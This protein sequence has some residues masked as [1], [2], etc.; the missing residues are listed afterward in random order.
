MATVDEDLNQLEKDIRQL[1][2]EYE[3]YFGGGRP[4]PPAD[5]VWRIEQVVK[6]YSEKGKQLNFAQRF[7]FN[8]LSQTYA[9]YQEVF[10]KRMKK[11][12]E[13]IVERHYGA[14]ARAIEA[15]REKAHAA[16]AERAAGASPPAAGRKPA[17]GA[18]FVMACK[19][20]DREGEKVQQL[21]QALVEAK[22]Q[23]GEKTDSLTLDNFQEFVRQKTEQLKKQKGAEQV[24]YAVT[25]EAG[26]VKLK[27]RVK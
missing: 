21:Y 18:G 19:D 15:Q 24:E 4:R 22:R 11:K 16:E 13:G 7:R 12:E 3:Q 14:A 5:T 9:K 10:R 6:R 8:N 26:Q 27:A 1:K 2:I 17:A 25:L 23:A 20:P